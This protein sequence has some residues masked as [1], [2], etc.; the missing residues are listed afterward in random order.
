MLSSGGLDS[1]TTVHWQ[2]QHGVDV[3]SITIDFA[4]PDE[5]NITEI[6]A[7]MID[8]GASEAIVVD[9]KPLLAEYMIQLLQGLGAYEGGYLNTTGIA[10]M[11]A[12]KIAL[13]EI[14]KRGISILSHGATG[15]GNDQVR[16]ELATLHHEPSFEIYAPWRD[17]IFIDELPGRKE[18]IDYCHKHG[19]KITATLEKPYSTDANFCGLTHEA[20][21]LEKLTVN[22][23][24]IK[25]VMGVRPEDAPDGREFVGIDFDHGMPVAINNEKMGLVD[26]F[27]TL[28]KIGGRNGIGIG[29]DVVENR[30]VG[31]KSRGIYEA[32]GA[33]ILAAA[34]EKMYQLILDGDRRRYFRDLSEKLGHE[35]YFGEWFTQRC[36]DLLAAISHMANDVTGSVGFILYKGNIMYAGVDG[37]VH[38]LYDAERAS[39]ERGG[40]QQHVSAQ[41]YMNIMDVSARALASA[42]LTRKE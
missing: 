21:E 29:I 18:M 26:I 4:Q 35:I 40:E 6:E 13:Y 20:G 10:R 30:R 16:F 12:V 38:S 3:T 31:I 32:P 41:G 2:S 42:S 27:L 8:A 5:Q 36:G 9:G 22:G 15:K 24:I 37:V 1:T 34:Y 33:T 23:D 11:A 14:R 25:F 17:Q 39:M 7:R 28:N 19:L